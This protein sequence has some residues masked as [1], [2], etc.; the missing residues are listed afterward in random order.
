MYGPAQI[1]S[2]AVVALEQVPSCTIAMECNGQNNKEHCSAVDANSHHY[3]ADEHGVDEEFLNELFQIADDNE[4][5]S[6]DEEHSMD[7]DEEVEQDVDSDSNSNCYSNHSGRYTTATT[8]SS[9]LPHCISPDPSPYKTTSIKSL[10]DEN[11]DDLKLPIMVNSSAV[12]LSQSCQ[13]PFQQQHQTYQPAL[14]APVCSNDGMINAYLLV[15]PVRQ[16]VFFP[17]QMISCQIG[18]RVEQMEFG[19]FM[20]PSFDKTVIEQYSQHVVNPYCSDT[21]QAT[22]I[23]TSSRSS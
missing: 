22:S 9:A 20:L 2:S 1:L 5:S 4:I 16:L 23:T 15:D 12:A 17:K 14:Q 11:V 3:H 10:N 13:L 6:E 8:S 21:Y 19:P 7:V 18:D